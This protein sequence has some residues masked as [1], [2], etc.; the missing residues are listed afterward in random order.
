M[1][2]EELSK[3]KV[4]APERTT[5]VEGSLKLVKET[6]RKRSWLKSLPREHRASSSSFSTQHRPSAED[7]SA[8]CVQPRTW[9]LGVCAH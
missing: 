9:L 7:S 5:T 1:E 8:L 4:T 6:S 2:M 3:L